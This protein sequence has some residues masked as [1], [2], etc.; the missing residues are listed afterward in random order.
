M[1]VLGQGIIELS[2]DGSKLNAAIA[3]ARKSIDGLGK[4]SKQSSE[5]ASRSIDRYIQSLDTQAKLIGK[6]A[7]EQTLYKLALKGA[8]DEQL[9]A[10]NSSL[11][12]AQKNRDTE[13]TISSLR[14]GFIALGAAAVA[15]LGGAIYMFDKLVKQAGDFQDLAEKIGDTGENIASLAVAAATAGISMDQVAKLSTKLSSG[16][17]GVDDESKSAGA[18]LTAL[19]LNISEFKKLNPTDQIETVA[20]AMANFEDGASKTAVA[21]ALFGKAGADALPFLKELSQE[22]S[23]QKIL[24]E[25]QIQLADAYADSQAKLSAEIG[26]Y[27]QAIA[28]DLIPTVNSFTSVLRDIASDQEFAAS[29]S[30]ILKGAM[31]ALIVIFQTI[32]VVGSEIAFVFNGV[33]R[34]IGA[35]AAQLVSLATLDIDGFTA[36]GDMVKKDAADARAE[37][38]RFQAKIMSIGTESAKIVEKTSEAVNK[39]KGKLAFTG[40]TKKGEDDKLAKS[41]LDKQLADIKASTDQEISIYANAQKII[42]AQKQAGLISEKTYNDSRIKFIFDHARAQ[43]TGLKQELEALKS[44]TL[45]GSAKDA[46]DQKIIET[47]SKL[48]KLY[49]DTAT[50]LDVLAIQLGAMG[51]DANFADSMSRGIDNF[52][53]KLVNLSQEASSAVESAMGA[54]VDGIASSISQAIVYG[55]NLEDSLKGVALNIADAFISA[56]IKMQIQ[57]MLLDKTTQIA[58]AATMTSQAQ[59]MVAM[60]GLNAFSSTAAIPIVGPALA[61]AAAAAASATAQGFAALVTSAATASIASARGGFDIPA[62]VNPLTQLHEKEMVLPAAQANVIRD[63][64]SNGVSGGGGII[65]NTTINIDSRSDRIQVMKDVQ[66]MIENGHSRLV[67]TLK[68]QRALA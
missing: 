32:T 65:D 62:G 2:A 6:S 7:S 51:N 14:S 17:S 50:S 23:R 15:A 22:G 46:N 48:N 52:K 19:G 24:T 18:A 30:S 33:G 9:R 55:K 31:N 4:S 60:S 38:D 54:A 44:V 5:A 13:K 57:K 64:A 12:L 34:E 66:R 68:R 29:A 25:E 28:T 53:S 37:L 10:A 8:T 35:I 16:L 39:P 41:A 20:K 11:V 59:A 56:F 1:T 42:D 40:A 27:A 36:I 61:P 58:Y 26:L 45:E 63:M 49:A 47:Q 43:E 21:M 3:E 67:D